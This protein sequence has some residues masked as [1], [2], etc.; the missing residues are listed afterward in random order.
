M[1]KKP[2]KIPDEAYDMI[3]DLWIKFKEELPF[4]LNALLFWTMINNVSIDRKRA[5]ISLLL[6]DVDKDGKMWDRL[7]KED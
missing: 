4:E 7:M 1:K 2:K 6:L 3:Y 5:V